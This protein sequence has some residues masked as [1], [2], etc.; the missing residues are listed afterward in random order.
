MSGND[1][2]QLGSEDDELGNDAAMMDSEDDAKRANF[3]DL[4]KDESDIIKAFLL[5][6]RFH[7]VFKELPPS[8]NIFYYSS[9]I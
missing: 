6:G 1:N 4:I 9:I 2:A 3:I 5:D 8:G 7:E